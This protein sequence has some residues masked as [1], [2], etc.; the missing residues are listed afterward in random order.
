MLRNTKPVAKCDRPKTSTMQ[1]VKEMSPS[2]LKRE[3]CPSAG[4]VSWGLYLSPP[5]LSPNC[6][7]GTKAVSEETSPPRSQM[8]SV[9]SPLAP[10]A[11]ALSVL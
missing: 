7:Q 3:T 4:V 9:Q 8:V 2:M 10:A 5:R 11:L 1:N 6:L